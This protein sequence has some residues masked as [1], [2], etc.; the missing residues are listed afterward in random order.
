[1]NTENQ[2]KQGILKKLLNQRRATKKGVEFLD[3][4]KIS[5]EEII[6]IAKFKP[7]KIGRSNTFSHNRTKIP[8]SPLCRSKSYTRKTPS[9]I[10]KQVASWQIDMGKLY[11]MYRYI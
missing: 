2:P 9:E 1:M 8:I 11:P 10:N 7:V 3:L 4:Q 5:D 6:S